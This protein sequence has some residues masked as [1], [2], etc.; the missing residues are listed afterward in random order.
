MNIKKTFELAVENHKRNN[1][2]TAEKFYKE[3]LKINPS[4]FETIFLLG[5]LSIAIK[6]FDRAIRL[7]NQAILI[8]PDHAQS[9]SNLGAAYK[10]V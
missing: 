9:Y 3:I 1:F 6:N 8:R 5:T 10:E 2:Q 7:L 4:H